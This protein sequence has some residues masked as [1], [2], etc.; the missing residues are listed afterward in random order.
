P[1]EPGPV[2]LVVGVLYSDEGLLEK[3]L[4]LLSEIHGPL[5]YRSPAFPFDR[6]DYYVPEMGSP[7]F[8][9]FVSHERLIHPRDLA[10]IKIGTNALEE[11]LAV[12]L[13]SGRLETGTVPERSDNPPEPFSNSPD[14]SSTESETSGGPEN[15][16]EA[17]PRRRVNFDP[18]YM[19]YDKFVLASA[20][21]NGQ[22]VYLDLG[23]WADLTLHYEKGRFDPYPWSFPDFKSGLYQEVFMEIRARFKAQ[24]KPQLSV[25]NK[26]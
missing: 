1:E 9:I 22:K 19:D 2:K 23:I 14:R 16:P 17:G 12:R 5:D 18:G 21:Y 10:R 3:G 8:R 25:Q 26:A 15:L 11:R 4:A 24:W 13:R 20:K 6:T 7:I